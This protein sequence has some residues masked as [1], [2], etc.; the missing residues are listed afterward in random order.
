MKLTTRFASVLVA[1]AIASPAQAG[2]SRRER[3]TF[4]AGYH[5]GYSYGMLVKTC[6]FYVWGNVSSEDLQFA[7]RYVR[8]D[9]D[10]TPYFVK[11]IAKSFR[12]MAQEKQEW[13][14]CAPIVLPIL[15]PATRPANRYQHADHWS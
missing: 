4:D 10:L 8:N 5:Y 14:Q 12:E 2:L 13:S 7:A 6:L 15:Q 11:R 9:K 3:K 1:L